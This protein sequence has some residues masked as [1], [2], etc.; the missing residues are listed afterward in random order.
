MNW[1]TSPPDVG[2]SAREKMTIDD[3]YYAWIPE[4]YTPERI[5]SSM[6]NLVALC[7]ALPDD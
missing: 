7:L 1:P 2:A 3:D 4:D 5:E 6:K